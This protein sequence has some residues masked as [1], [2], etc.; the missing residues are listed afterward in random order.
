MPKKIFLFFFAC[1]VLFLSACD[2]AENDVSD[3]SQSVEYETVANEGEVI[4][5]VPENELKV[6]VEGEEVSFSA[7]NTTVYGD[8]FVGKNAE[9]FTKVDEL[10]FISTKNEEYADEVVTGSVT[11]VT[12]TSLTV[13]TQDGDRNFSLDDADVLTE[14]PLSVGDT[15]SVSSFSDGESLL[16]KCLEH[17]GG[18]LTGEIHTVTQDLLI[19]KEDNGILYPFLISSLHAPPKVEGER[20]SVSY[21]GTLSGYY[22]ATA[23]TEVSQDGEASGT[24]EGYVTDF[25][26][27]M[28]AI[29]D[30]HGAQ[31]SLFRTA[32][33]KFSNGRLLIGDYVSISYGT[34]AEGNM[35]ADDLVII[36]YN[37]GGELSLTGIVTRYDR[38]VLVLRTKSGNEHIFSHNEATATYTKS[39]EPQIL[40]EVTVDFRYLSDGTAHAHTITE[41]DY[42]PP[43][44]TVTCTVHSQDD[45]HLTI[46]TTQGEMTLLKNGA[47][48]V[49]N[50]PLVTGDALTIEYLERPSGAHELLT[51][52]VT[53]EATRGEPSALE[54][55]VSGV[56]EGEL[57]YYNEDEE[58]VCVKDISGILHV[59]SVEDVDMPTDEL[60]EI[61]HFT[62]QYLSE[63]DGGK[64]AVLVTVSE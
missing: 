28:V 52:S 60:E 46:T 22:Y 56:A 31:Y 64:T 34:D 54:F 33:N 20:V 24:I 8:I 55:G 12:E 6:L 37:T 35:V 44:E 50:H 32:D 15:V 9:F 47:T 41:Y 25:T 42:D 43:I 11:A 49:A 13:V 5:F 59:I 53:T 58:L 19:L 4:S 48:V 2:N 7:V 63:E 3:N 1:T 38:G 39:G 21:S 17:S 27:D 10:L 18:I 36:R 30:E 45:T 61:E 57:L 14:F 40:S 29:R 62:V 23:V 16:V 26:G 51:A